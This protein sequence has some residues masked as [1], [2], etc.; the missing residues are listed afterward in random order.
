MDIAVFSA[1]PYDRQFLDAANADRRHRLKYFDDPLNAETVDLAAGHRGICVFVND[2][3]DAPVL[4]A[5]ARGGTQL[6]ALRCTGFNNVDLQAAAD[7]GIKVVRVVD[8][9][10]NSVAEHAV[11]LLMAVNRKVH[12]AYNRTRD[13]NFALDGLMGFDLCGKTVAVIGTGKIGRVFARIML[14]F[15]C[16]VIGYDAYRSPEFEALGARYADAG[17]IGANADIV[18][19]HCPLTPQTYHII[20]AQTLARAKRGSL[21]INTSRGGLVDTEAVIDA[22]KSGQLGGLAIDVYE[23]EAGVFFRDLSGTI[24]DDDVLQRLMTFPNVIVTGHQAFL[25]RE[26]V[27]TICET[28]LRSITEFETGQPLTNEITAVMERKP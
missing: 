18:S 11:A 16:N 3:A 4:E 6:V 22:L 2:V 26:A 15:G 17:E 19:L 27:S 14:G 1:K 7:L 13:F 10:P 8:Y 12:R 25:T 5:L 9:S 23:Q 28:T 24:V 20:G 21:L